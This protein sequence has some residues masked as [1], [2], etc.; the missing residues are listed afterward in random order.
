MSR[1]S[2]DLAI[3]KDMPGVGIPQLEAATAP[4][5]QPDEQEPGRCFLTSRPRTA[6]RA[7]RTARIARIARIAAAAYPS[8]TLS[9]KASSRASTALLERG[10]RED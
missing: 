8:A 5:L 7:R 3:G 10:R 9:A 4:A 6:C 2:L 1:T